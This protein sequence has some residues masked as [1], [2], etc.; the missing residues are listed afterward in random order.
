MADFLN[1][2]QLWIAAENR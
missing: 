1:T 2:A